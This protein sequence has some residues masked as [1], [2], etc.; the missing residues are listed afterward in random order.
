MSKK[1]AT[2]TTSSREFRGDFDFYFNL[3]DKGKVVEITEKRSPIAH[4]FKLATNNNKDAVCNIDAHYTLSDLRQNFM[5]IFDGLK[6]E[7][8]TIQINRFEKPPIVIS[9]QLN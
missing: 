4:I 8:S 3:A 7:P 1:I 9:S 6:K 5:Q 2:S